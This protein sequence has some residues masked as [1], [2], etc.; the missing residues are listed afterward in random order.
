GRRLRLSRD[1]MRLIAP[2]SAAAGL[3]A[4]FNAPISAVLFVIEEVIGRWTA[5]ILGSV[6][7]SAVSSVVVMRW[8]LGSEPLFRIPLVEMTQPSELLAYSVLGIV[9]GLASIG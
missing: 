9:G 8:F 7:L 2:V 1:H 3:A 4:A 5:G 6:V